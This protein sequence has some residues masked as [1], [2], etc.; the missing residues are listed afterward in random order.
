MT[1]AT[2]MPTRT[3]GAQA[4]RFI[5]PVVVVAGLALLST[6]TGIPWTGA[7]EA[8]TGIHLQADPGQGATLTISKLDPGE[9]ATKTVTIRNSGS[10][11]SRLSFEENAAPATFAGGQL[12]LKIQQDGHTVYDG[13]FGE[14]NDV[15]QDAGTL[16]PAGSSKFTF[17][18][19]LPDDAP[20]V[21]QGDPAVATYSWV[22]S[23]SASG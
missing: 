2:T 18:V 3:T 15:S 5:I 11:E 17:T 10:A 7:S 23:D 19:S 1:I 14:M 9:S 21:N 12:H 22:N 8:A 6:V 4:K 13:R 20:F 16:P